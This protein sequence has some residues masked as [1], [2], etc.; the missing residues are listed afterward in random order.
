MSATANYLYDGAN[1]AETIDQSGNMVGRYVGG[2]GID[3]PL[4][5]LG[6]GT[7]SYYEQDGLGSVTSLTSATGAL[8][9]SYTYDTFGNPNASTGSLVNPLLYDG[10]EYDPE[11]GL[12]YYRARYYDPRPGRFLSEDPLEFAGGGANFYGYVGNRPTNRIDPSGRGG[13]NPVSAWWAGLGRNANFAWNWFWET[14]NFGDAT[15]IQFN[16]RD[17]LY[18]GPNTPETQDMMNSAGG[19]Y[20]QL[21]YVFHY[22]CK[23]SPQNN[24]FPTWAGYALTTQDPSNTAFQV[25]AFSFDIT[26]MGDGTVQYTMYNK[27]GWYSL[28]GGLN[29]GRGDHDRQPAFP[30]HE[31]TQ[32]GGNIRQIFQS[33]RPK[34]CGC[35]NE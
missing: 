18:Y 23:G 29:R 15:H 30:M 12:L 25:G 31:A 6:S 35:G 33:R 26:D 8:L 21:L 17:F 32:F 9:N 11:I 20:M 2:G 14:D 5:E 22:K 19:I 13:Q 34:P 28:T 27:A 16:G 7:A 1:P 10:H 3:E 24:N 4:A